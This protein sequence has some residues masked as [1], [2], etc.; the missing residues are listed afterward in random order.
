MRRIPITP[1]DDWKKK[2]ESV[3]LTYHTTDAG[4]I[5][6]DE[7]AYY[8][9]TSAE[10]DQIEVATYALN[11]LCLNAV[12]HIIANALWEDFQIPRGY[13]DYLCKSWDEDEIS[14]VGRF[15]LLC[16]GV[17]PPKLA[18]YNADTP[19]A[20]VEA[21]V[22]QWFWLQE[23]AADVDQFNSIHEKLLEV[24]RRVKD[25]FG[26]PVTFVSVADHVE[27][28]MTVTYLQDI[29]I[30]T[31]SKT[32]YQPIS[33]LG[34]NAARRTFV[35]PRERTL[36]LIFKLYPW[37]WLFHEEFGKFLGEATTRWLEPPWKALLSNK[38]LL[39]LLW[40]LNPDHPNLLPASW[41]P[42]PGKCVEK[43]A[44]GREGAN[45]TILEDGKTL[46]S[47]PG[48]YGGPFIYQ[49]FH[50]TPRFDGRTAVLGSWLINGYA[51]GIGIREDESEITSN[52]SR[53]V[54]H[55]IAG[56]STAL[57]SQETGIRAT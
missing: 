11:E 49:Q 21:S 20:L 50:E 54:P 52:T 23:T 18:E 53:F 2:V 34:W 9:F 45:I 14:V 39:P 6:W 29:A 47:T 51:C 5:Y 25:E 15:D 24:W 32:Q 57:K 31:G 37:E 46:R 40:E 43:P 3:G 27:D 35:D 56:P 8:E 41:D 1:R 42:L 33:A 55:R 7:S 17:N 4:D 44:L 38:A 19:T 36:G 26:C 22:A 30:Q 48:D 16:D 28:F 10:I 12:G 13:I